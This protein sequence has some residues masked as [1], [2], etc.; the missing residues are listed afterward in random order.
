MS[1]GHWILYGNFTPS[2]FI[3]ITGMFRVTK[4]RY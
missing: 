2:S 3:E 4:T 1:F